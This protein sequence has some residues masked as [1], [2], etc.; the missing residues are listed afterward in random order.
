[1]AALTINLGTDGGLDLATIDT[2]AASG[3]GDTFL[4]DGKTMFF[5]TNGSG[6]SINV[7]FAAVVDKVVAVGAGLTLAFMLNAGTYNNPSGSVVVTYSAVTSVTVGAISY[8]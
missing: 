3:A 2:A 8:A 5:V 4:N 1:M 7:T 6:G